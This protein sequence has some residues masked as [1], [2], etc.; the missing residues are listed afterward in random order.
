MMAA[1][2]IAVTDFS[3]PDRGLLRDSLHRLMRN[4][5]AMLGL[6]I[7][8]VF[9]LAA[10][11]APL[12]T[13]YAPDQG[14][15]IDQLQGPSRAHLMGTDLQGRDEFS[16]LLYGARLSIG[17]SL[18]SVIIG[19]VMGVALGVLAGVG[20]R[21]LDSVVMRFVDVLLALPGILLAIGIVA[22]LGQGFGQ[23]MIAVAVTN[24]P[25]FARI[26]RS[27]LLDIRESDFVLAARAAGAGPI[28][29]MMRHLLPNSLTPLIVTATLAM[30]TAIISV[31]GLGFLGL[32]PPD[33]RIAEW[34]GMLTDS[35]RFLRAAPYL[36]FF[37]AIA[38][39]SLVI[40]FNLLGDGLRESF[41]PRLRR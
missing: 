12:L 26:L 17:I 4:K 9:I 36:L 41:D 10:I 33:P 18:I 27:S 11:L 8:T 3:A 5:P 20:G 2:E 23:I 24:A 28:R 19:L 29:V 21:A 15:V 38:I 34:G 25:N 14:N 31:A 35:T 1:R 16:R 39:S 6:G 30:A 37:P 13:P 32:G 7:I 40:G 22:W